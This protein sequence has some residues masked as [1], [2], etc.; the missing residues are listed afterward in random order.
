MIETEPKK[1]YIHL[2]NYTVEEGTIALTA[3]DLCFSNSEEETTLYEGTP[4]ILETVNNKG[5]LELTDF[6]GRR[7]NADFVTYFSNSFLPI[8]QND[9]KLLLGDKTELK[10]Q[11]MRKLFHYAGLTIFDIL[12]LVVFIIFAKQPNLDI[13]IFLLVL[14]LAFLAVVLTNILVSDRISK[15]IYHKSACTV[16][17][18]WENKEQNTEELRTILKKKGELNE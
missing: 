9:I 2:G 3:V 16:K 18:F 15:G 14:I 12:S 13:N 17:M 8:D 5:K 4:V 7:Y 6:E 1:K 10:K 11:K